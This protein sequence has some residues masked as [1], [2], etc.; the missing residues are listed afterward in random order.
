MET[1]E[2]KLP[3]L[4]ALLPELKLAFDNHE[5]AMDA[6]KGPEDIKAWE[7]AIAA[8][9]ALSERVCRTLAEETPNSYDTLRQVFK[10]NDRFGLWFGSNAY[11]FL[12][13]VA[14]TGHFNHH[15]HPKPA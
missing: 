9:G 6:V 4:A 3:K 1:V 7:D 13:G 12:W 8:F 15:N 11:W 2:F 14:V 5:K 10:P